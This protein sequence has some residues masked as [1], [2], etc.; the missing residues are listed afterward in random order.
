LLLEQSKECQFSE[1]AEV[2]ATGMGFTICGFHACVFCNPRTLCSRVFSDSHRFHRDGV[3]AGGI[4]NRGDAGRNIARGPA[5]SQLDLSLGKH[6]PI[7][8]QW[9]VEFRTEVFNVF[10]RAQLADPSGDVTVPSQ[11]G[12]IQSTVNTTQIGTGTPRQ[13]QFMLRVSF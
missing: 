6:F 13:I 3:D 9:A 11:F 2:K 10:N 7:N 5:F 12:I 1:T 4:S 8:E